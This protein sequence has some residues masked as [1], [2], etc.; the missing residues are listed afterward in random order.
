VTNR[1]VHLTVALMTGVNKLECFSSDSSS[2]S[3]RELFGNGL[4][5]QA[6]KDKLTNRL[7]H[8]TVVLMTGVNKL[9]CFFPTVQAREGKRR[10]LRQS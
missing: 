4:L 10:R 3:K 7:V 9:A 5:R 8:L 1:L 6:D 2:K